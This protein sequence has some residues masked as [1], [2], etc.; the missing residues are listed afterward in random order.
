MCTC[1]IFFSAILN[2]CSLLTVQCTRECGVA[3]VG[4]GEYD[5][6]LPHVAGDLG[7]ELLA[8][9]RERVA[10]RADRHAPRRS[11]RAAVDEAEV[12]VVFKVHERLDLEAVVEVV[13]RRMNVN[14]STTPDTQRVRPGVASETRAE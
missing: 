5:A 2:V 9:R 10:H 4:G 7:Q 3:G 13:L 14:T 11:Q 12:A 6:V 1:A 8:L